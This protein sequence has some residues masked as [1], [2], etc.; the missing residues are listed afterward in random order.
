MASSGRVQNLELTSILLQCVRPQIWAII[1]MNLCALCMLCCRTAF[2]VCG[3]KHTHKLPLGFTTNTRAW[4]RSDASLMSNFLMT[5]MDFILS[6][7]FFNESQR[8]SGTLLGE[9]TI[10]TASGF[11]SK[12]TTP[13][14]IVTTPS[15]TSGYNFIT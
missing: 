11:T 1:Y 7:S 13:F 12:C 14:F 5:F 10:G 9:H 2:K 6:N 4:T 8:A 3:S 15:N